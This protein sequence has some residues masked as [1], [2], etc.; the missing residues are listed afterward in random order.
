[1]TILE[2][3][4][5]SV[6]RP[7]ESQVGC[8]EARVGFVSQNRPSAGDMGLSTGWAT[9]GVSPLMEALTHLE[10]LALPVGFRA[11]FPYPG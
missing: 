3:A 7:V 10:D 5:P 1:M 11:A 4:P 8:R 6:R 2:V 9:V